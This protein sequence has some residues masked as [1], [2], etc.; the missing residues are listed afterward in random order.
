MKTVFIRMR[1]I[2]HANLIHRFH[3]R[4]IAGC[5]LQ[6]IREQ[7]ELLAATMIPTF[8]HLTLT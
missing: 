4:R 7:P 5:Q 2:E 8:R 1:K 6:K 3:Q